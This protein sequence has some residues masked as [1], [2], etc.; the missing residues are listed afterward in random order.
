MTNPSFVFLS[1]EHKILFKMKAVKP[2]GYF[3]NF[4]GDTELCRNPE[5]ELSRHRGLEVCRNC[6]S[7]G[8]EVCRHPF[9]RGWKFADTFH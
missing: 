2:F 6:F 8:M 1:S 4:N 3:I 7:S 5:L 9:L